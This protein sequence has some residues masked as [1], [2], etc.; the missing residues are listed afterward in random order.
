M[1]AVGDPFKTG[2]IAMN[3][4]GVWGFWVYSDITAFEVGAAAFPIGK[5]TNKPVIFTDRGSPVRAKTRMPPGSS[6]RCWSDPKEGAKSYMET[7]TV[8]PP[9]AE[10]LPEWYDIIGK[11]MSVARRRPAK[12]L[13]EGS[14]TKG[15]ESAN[16]LLV[17]FDQMESMVSNERQAIF[18]DKSPAAEVM[19]TRGSTKLEELAAEARKHYQ[20]KPENQYL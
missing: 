3:L 14:M 15:Y 7:T 20:E 9:A 12:Q 18:L 16:H 11:R 6:P 4:N 19:P 5:V 8:V 10:L 17:S 1:T 2:R 13:I